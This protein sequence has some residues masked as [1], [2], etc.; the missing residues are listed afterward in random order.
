MS[1]TC[2]GRATNTAT[3]ANSFAALTAKLTGPAGY[4][5]PR[6]PVERHAKTLSES[7]SSR[8]LRPLLMIAM[9]HCSG[10]AGWK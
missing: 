3:Y 1:Q 10:K 9:V 5:V 7:Q 4:I 8:V 2:V 6:L